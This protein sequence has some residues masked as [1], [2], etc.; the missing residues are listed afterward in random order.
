ML[1]ACGVLMIL[2]VL[3]VDWLPFVDVPPHVAE[4]A[5]LANYLVPEFRFQEFYELGRWLHPYTPHRVV[6]AGIAEL[7]GPMAA[8]RL[9][10]AAYLGLAMY[11]AVRL[12]HFVGGRRSAVLVLPFV[13]Y[14]FPLHFG[15]IP[16]CFATAVL[17][18]GLYWTERWLAGDGRSGSITVLLV[19]SLLF[20]LHPQAFLYWLVI[21]PLLVLLWSAANGRDRRKTGVMVGSLIPA[22]AMFVAYAIASGKPDAIAQGSAGWPHPLTRLQNL[23]RYL[24]GMWDDPW[25]YIVALVAVG[26][27]LWA[28]V[29]WG[30]RQSSVDNKRLSR[31]WEHRYLLVVIALFAGSMVLPESL[32][33]AY[34]ASRLPSMALLVLPVALAMDAR[35][36]HRAFVVG[37][38]GLSLAFA[39]LVAVQMFRFDAESGSF[40]EIVDNIPVGAAVRCNID[41][42]HSDQ[43]TLPSYRHFCSY[44]TAEKGGLNGFLFRKLGIDYSAPYQIPQGLLYF[45]QFDATRRFDFRQFGDLFDYYVVRDPADITVYDD[46]E[47]LGEFFA[48]VVRSGEW[49]LYRRIRSFQDPANGQAPAAS[50]PSEG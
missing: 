17:L 43:F 2:P 41:A 13:L 16:Y 5:I 28:G 50:P 42:G 9:F 39:V 3:L 6:L 12:I 4:V 47:A 1:I 19:P 11:F 23:P 29:A 35:W 31:F 26:W 22:L 14:S 15:F 18:G 46:P 21:G 45:W 44:I 24:G 27:W 40:S 49:R 38:A 32:M 20:L 36:D 48:P 33:Q 25:I 10:I 30:G 8:Y 37:A 34:I 7:I